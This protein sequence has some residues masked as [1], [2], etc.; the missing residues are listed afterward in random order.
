MAASNAL[1]GAEEQIAKGD[2]RRANIRLRDGLESLGDVFLGSDVLDD[3]GQRLSAAASA[4]WDEK[5]EVAA[6]LRQSTLA[7]RLSHYA[8]LQNLRKCPTPTQSA[9]MDLPL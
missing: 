3:S 9:T 8:Q 1:G 4:E 6:R 5:L 2:Y 7:D